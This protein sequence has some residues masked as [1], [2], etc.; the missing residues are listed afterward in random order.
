MSLISKFGLGFFLQYNATGATGGI[1][2]TRKSVRQLEMGFRDVAIGINSVSSSINR[3]AGIATA[4]LAL[5][6]GA[7]TA[8]LSDYL[9]FDDQL[10]QIGGTIGSKAFRPM[11]E[12]LKRTAQDMAL[13]FGLAPSKVAEGMKAAAKAGATGL[14]DMSK[15]TQAALRMATAD[16]EI[17]AEDA[18]K[19]IKEFASQSQIDLAQGTNASDLSDLIL[20]ASNM[21]VTN[22]KGIGDSLKYVAAAAHDAGVPIEETMAQIVML[23]NAGLSGTMAGTALGRMYEQLGKGP[24]QKALDALGIKAESAAGKIR[25]LVPIAVDF[26]KKTKNFGDIDKLTLARMI[27]ESRGARGLRV[28]GRDAEIYGETLRSLKDSAGYGLD[29]VAM[30]S[31][32]LKMSFE[33][34]KAG[35][36][37]VAGSIAD[38]F[39]TEISGAIQTAI[40]WTTELV[41]ALRDL[42]DGKSLT[43]YSQ[44]V[45][46]FVSG[47]ENALER[48]KKFFATLQNG[49]QQAKTYLEPFTKNMSDFGVTMLIL[50]P[51][52]AP[53]VGVLAA[54]L[55]IVTALITG[56]I[57][58]VQ[59]FIG[60]GKIVGSVTAMFGIG[61]EAGLTGAVMGFLTSPWGLAIA[62]GLAILAVFGDWDD[63]KSIATSVW[64]IMKTLGGGIKTVLTPAFAALGLVAKPIISIFRDVLEAVS[65]L[66]KVI[67]DNEYTK[68]L[69]GGVLGAAFT[70]LGVTVGTVMAPLEAVAS[71]LRDIIDLIKEMQKLMPTAIASDIGSA[72]KGI[73]SASGMPTSTGDGVGKAT[74]GAFGSV[75]PKPVEASPV[76]PKL[77]VLTPT[78][79]GQND[80]IEAMPQKQ[81]REFAKVEVK[82]ELTTDGRKLAGASARY[83]LE[84]AERGGAKF[85]PWQRQRVNERGLSPALNGVA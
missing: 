15:L 83:T 81:F 38:N 72:F 9:D 2:K 48:S 58:V 49:F 17:S 51:I 45:Q 73:K 74:L 18:V 66:F 44:S 67:F 43:G 32:G 31:E 12:E 37:I 5:A 52:L 35:A 8:L 21:A 79:S 3:L 70:A 55:G 62:G 16:A 40:A 82:T 25:G 28:L 7:T 46:D 20:K 13:T 11:R 6:A 41:R 10:Q 76:M 85:T 14:A 4:G 56:V 68:G 69:I 77:D 29:A 47:V 50:S 60:L 19:V 22:V 54:A 71:V 59:I 33:R 78:S 64:E 27:S 36:Q 24:A 53:L 34:L 23:S 42:K 63:I 84:L 57:G 26:F 30:R 75:K 1:D 61:G 39:G 65:S 80:A